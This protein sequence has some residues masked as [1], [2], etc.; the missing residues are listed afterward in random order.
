MTQERLDKQWQKKGLTA[1]STDAILGT[2]GHYG[3]T[4]DEAAFKSAAATKFPLEL[5]MGWAETWKATGPFGPL[6][7]PA[8][9]EL[10]RRWVKSVQPSDVAVSLR[11]LLIAGDAALK[12]KDGFTQALE[13]MESKASQ[14]PAGDPRERFMAEVVLHLRNVSTPIDVLA[15]ELAQ[16]G[17]VAEAERLVKLEES[18]FPLR[19]GVS[20]ALVAAAKGQVEPAVT[21]LTTLVKDG[22]KDPYA[23][24]SAMD[25]LLRLN[26]PRPAYTPALEMAEV[27]LEK[28][29][30]ELFDELMRR[31]QRIHQATAELPEEATNHV[32]LDALLDAL[33]H[34]HHH[35]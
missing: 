33:Q 9:E 31:L 8:V 15:E 22:A 34:H 11:A 16:A 25:A 20:A 19:A 21:A 28:H 32:R 2:L 5:A 10:W 35:H 29:D 6:P 12:G 13:T 1:Y 4:I 30:H 27:A 24:V 23:R 18:L 3:L 14:V 17:K 7:V 26:R